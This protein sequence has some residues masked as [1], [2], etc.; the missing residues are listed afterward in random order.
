MKRDPR[1][2]VRLLAFARPYRW[3][4]VVGVVATL[5]S[6]GLN[7]VFPALFG[8][9][10]DAS[11][12]KVGSTDTSQLDRTVVALLGIFALSAVFGAAQSFLLSRVGA[13]VV[14]DL[15]RAVFA[16]LLTLSPR[17]FGE[18]KTGDLTS[19]LTSDVGTVQTV[20]STALAQLAAQSVSLVGAVVLLVTTSPRLSLLTLAVIP[21]VI[22]TAVTI[23]RRIRQVSREVQDAVAGANASAEEA[24]SGVR[25]VQSFTAEGVEEGRYGQGVTQSF[26]A[27]LKRARLQ[28][29]MAGVMSFLTFGALAVVLWYGGRLVMAG[30][31][32]PGNLV[33]FL[34][35]ALQVGGTVV[36]LTGVFNQFQEALGA[37][38]RIFELLDER[39]DLP[40]PAQP[41]PLARAEGRVSFEGVSFTYDG[42]Q[43][44]GTRAA[45]LRDVTLDV[46]AGQVVALVGPSGAG[47]TTLVNLI[48]RFWDVTG[49][50]LRVDGR[51]VRDYALA[52]LR[53]QVGLVP[54]E[55]LLFSGSI[56]EN[57][58]Y[59]RP[60][61]RPDEVEAAAR[62]ANAHEFIRAFP[63]GY[64]TVVGERGVK[65]SGGQRQRVAIARAILKDPRILI[66]D[67]A[68]S[69]LDNES[70]SLVQAALERLMQGRTTFVIAHRLSTI[71]NADRILVMDAGRVTED[72]T[73]AQLLAAGGLYRDLYELQF[74]AEQDAQ[75]DLN[76]T[77]T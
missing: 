46:P 44:E 10:I 13:G 39:S 2:L 57:I 37:S 35:Y 51:D 77:T 8:R 47:K 66:L 14:A 62:A 5:I 25:V 72:G 31:L 64:E 75:A 36:A 70:E 48:P 1:Q 58:L 4:F 24:I 55:T 68:T 12:L 27:A 54:Q 33:T 71:R 30:S 15:R 22:G 50:T 34:F 20:T 53:A 63:H 42:D 32:T 9:L 21:L 41:A 74:R 49:G 16:H 69:A 7:L 38:G 60:G 17:F 26:L 6:S 19:R 52:D 11:F 23:G 56:R 28:A 76:L 29:L 18:H 61:A 59:G 3:V 43:T 65:L 45:V 67:E 40:Q 73:H